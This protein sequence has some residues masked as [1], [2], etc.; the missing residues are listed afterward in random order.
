MTADEQLAT[1]LAT[2]TPHF[3]VIRLH[4]LL[5][6]DLALQKLRKGITCMLSMVPVAV[7]SPE[8][9]NKQV[10][11]TADRTRAHYASTAEATAHPRSAVFCSAAHVQQTQHVC[12]CFPAAPQWLASTPAGLL[13]AAAA[14]RHHHSPTRCYL[15]GMLLA[16]VPSSA[17]KL[18]MTAACSCSLAG[19]QGRRQT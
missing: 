8:H 11:S 4:Q 12:T 15:P 14:G 19:Q 7:P 13:Q 18:Y 6:M 3:T 5:S 17:A 2:H 16:R 10:Q 1:S 9:C